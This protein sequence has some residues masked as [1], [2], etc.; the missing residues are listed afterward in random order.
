M[1]SRE[2]VS[3]MAHKVCIKTEVMVKE[4]K[5]KKKTWPN[6]TKEGQRMIELESEKPSEKR[7][8]QKNDGQ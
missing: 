4:T 2:C 3:K 1:G 7:R 6:M 5:K 8:A